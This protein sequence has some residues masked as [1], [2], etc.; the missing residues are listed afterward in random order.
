MDQNLPFLLVLNI[1]NTALDQLCSVLGVE[2]AALGLAALPCVHKLLARQLAAVTIQGLW[3]LR[4]K[5]L[6][7]ICV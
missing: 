4:N 7:R 6:P 3:G 2:E 1:F 5:A